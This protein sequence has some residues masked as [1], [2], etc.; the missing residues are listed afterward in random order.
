MDDSEILRLADIELDAFFDQLFPNGFAGED[1]LN[2][3]APE[4]WK[5]SPLL[6]CFHPSAEQLF[7]ER[8]QIHRNIE[9]FI[10]AMRKRSDQATHV[11]R[12]EPKLEEIRAEWKETQVNIADEVTELVGNC[13]WD[14]FSDNHDVVAADGRRVDIGSFRGASA[15]LD[16]YLRRASGE[17][18]SWKEGDYMH[19][20]MGTIWIGGRTDLIVVYSMIFRRLKQ[21][22]ADW[23]YSFPEIYFANFSSLKAEFKEPSM[24][25]PSE[26]W[27]ASQEEEKHQAEL[28]KLQ[29]ELNEINV[30]SRKEAMDMPVPSTVRGYQYVYASNPRGWP[31]V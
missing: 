13:L 4:G 17:I 14:V 9:G 5:Y 16:G 21:L 27:K 25:S 30:Q 29:A 2:E 28:E 6:S 11:P 22:G 8:L 19:F 10:K 15:F 20:Y 31:P 18:P 7:K 23:V 1:V 3:I 12:P 24:Y 26:G